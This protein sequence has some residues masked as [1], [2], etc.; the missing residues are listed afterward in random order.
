MAF[1]PATIPESLKVA[2]REKRCAMMVGAGASVR[3]WTSDLG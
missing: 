3:S 2:Y 1:D